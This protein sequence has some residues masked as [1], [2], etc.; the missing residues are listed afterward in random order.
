MN[1]QY[2]FRSLDGGATWEQ[3]GLPSGDQ[4]VVVEGISFASER[5]G[6]LLSPGPPATQCMAQ[7]VRLWYTS[8]VGGTWQQSTPS[9][10]EERRCKEA[11]AFV[12]ASRGFLAAWDPNSPPVL[13]R[14]PDGG[15]T[16]A[17]S[18][19]LPDPPGFTTRAGGF[20]LRAGRVR[21]FGATLLVP[22]RAS[23]GQVAYVYRSGDGG[24]TWSYAAAVPPGEGAFALIT[25]TRWIVLGA[26]GRSLE[27]TDGGAS[28]HPYATDYAQAAPVAPVVVFADDRVGYATV[29]GLIQRSLDGGARWSPIPSPG[30][31]SA[32]A[33]QP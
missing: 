29:R 22:V 24:A 2:L 15:R 33:G 9:G 13:Y 8:D 31:S 25:A 19:P 17:A 7:G 28:W 30:T 12:D 16:W 5:E 20:T 10:V 23:G 26:P 32:S 27:T 1:S 21:A 6:W 11:L 4:G 14:T 18:G 3:R